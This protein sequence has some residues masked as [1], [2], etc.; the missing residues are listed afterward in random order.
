MQQRGSRSGAE[1][2]QSQVGGGRSPGWKEGS[3]KE[4]GGKIGPVCGLCSEADAFPG[5]SA[6]S[7]TAAEQAR[8]TRRWGRGSCQQERLGCAAGEVCSQGEASAGSLSAPGQTCPQEGLLN[9][10]VITQIQ[11]PINFLLYN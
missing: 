6:A 5:R 7:T 4:Q 9:C 2:R 3:S 10:N 11:Y 8:L 1:D